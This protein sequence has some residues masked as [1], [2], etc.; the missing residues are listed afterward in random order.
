M[1]ALLAPKSVAIIGASE[2]P[3]RI[4]G[5]LISFIYKHGYEGNICLV[6]PKYENIKGMRCYPSILESPH[7]ID[8]ALIAV[9]EKKVT[10]VLSECG[11]FNVKSAIIFSAGFAETGDHARQAELKK[12]AADKN[13]RVCGPNCVGIL[14]FHDGIALSFS[15][16]LE[17]DALIPGNIAFISQSGALGGSLLNRA[18]DRGI[19]F[20]YFI[21]TGNEA[22]LEVSDYIKYLALNDERTTVIAAVIEGFKDGSKFVEATEFALKRQKP[23]I[24][25]KI[26]VTEAGKRAASSHTGALAGSDFVI[27]NILRQQ[28]I[29]RVRHYDELFETASLFSKGRIPKG[30]RVGILTTTGGGGVLMAD[31]FVKSGLEIPEPS[32]KTRKIASKEISSFAQVANPFDLTAQLIQNPQMFPKVLNLFIEDDNFDIILIINSMTAGKRSETRALDILNGAK[33]STK[34]IVTWWAAGS[35]SGPGFEVLDG[36]EVTLFKSPD[37]CSTAVRKLVEYYDHIKMYQAVRTSD[38]GKLDITNLDEAKRMLSSK[39]GQLSEHQSKNLLKLFDIKV[40]EEKLAK[41]PEEAIR[42]AEDIGYPIALKI[43]SPDIAHKTKAKAM[44]LNIVSEDQI[45]PAYDEII[46]NAKSYD[47]SAKINGILVQ[48]MVHNGLETIVGIS[49]DPQ[50]GPVIVFGLGGVFVNV[51]EDF[52]LR[53]VPIEKLDAEL[54]IKETKAAH[55][56]AGKPMNNPLDV[57]AVIETLLKVSNLALSLKDYIAELD[58]NPLWVFQK[59]YGVKALDGLVVLK[60]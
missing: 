27:E 47:Q 17:I 29:I 15:Q 22:D 59:G 4:G 42:F 16:F 49:Q 57:D 13:I 46:A 60:Q 34:P 7:P 37:R 5:R 25:L 54:M 56:L 32:S 14:N 12:L 2:D 30:N 53:M 39:C 44:K 10:E 21:S 55:I 52:A 9:P 1:K 26:G 8:C 23:V 50:F 43:D 33:G 51:I 48:E 24:V 40:T 58:I 36:S 28:G 31:Y 11:E 20:S 18:Q 35:L 19:G 45:Q 38:V 41:S 6:N 3:T